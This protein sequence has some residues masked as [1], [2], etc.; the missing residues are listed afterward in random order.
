MWKSRNVRLDRETHHRSCSRKLAIEQLE[1]RVVL[2]MAPLYDP[3]AV[4]G[5]VGG[6]ISNDGAVVALA[7]DSTD[8]PPLAPRKV[9]I[10]RGDGENVDVTPKVGKLVNNAV[11]L[12]GD[13]A[14]GWMEQ[15]PGDAKLS[16]WDRSGIPTS[17]VFSVP[18]AYDAH[19][20]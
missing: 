5:A 12:I 4:N 17:I 9:I 3:I 13:V 15:S 10:D 11:K 14:Y 1:K 2:T 18:D 8:F 16:K 20:N 7:I 6:S 19:L